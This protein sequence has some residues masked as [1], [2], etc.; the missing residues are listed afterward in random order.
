LIF[1]ACWGFYCIDVCCT[2]GVIKKGNLEWMHV[3]CRRV[4]A[5]G[6]RGRMDMDRGDEVRV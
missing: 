3:A 6:G 4:C 2:G 1:F 5:A